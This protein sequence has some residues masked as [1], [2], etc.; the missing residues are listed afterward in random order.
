MAIP[1]LASSLSGATYE[2]ATR[3]TSG[4]TTNAKTGVGS[5]EA[6]SGAGHF[7]ETMNQLLE[8]TGTSTAEARTEAMSLL[9]G[10]TDS[11][12]SIVLAGEKAEI[13]LQ[14]TLQ[15][16]NKVLDAYNEVMR[17]QI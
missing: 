10:E 17:M 11:I 4:V 7:S 13:A 15:I 6:V 16:R 2:F 3:G 5:P 14:L 1:P 12:H 8:Q 9:T